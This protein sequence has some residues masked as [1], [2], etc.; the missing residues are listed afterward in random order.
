MLQPINADHKQAALSVP[1]PT[2]APNTDGADQPPRIA[3]R[4]VNPDHARH[5]SHPRH[6]PQ[7]NLPIVPNHPYHWRHYHQIVQRRVYQH[8]ILLILVITRNGQ[9]IE[10]PIAIGWRQIKSM[11]RPSV[12]HIW[13]LALRVYQVMVSLNHIMVIQRIIQSM[14][15]SI[16]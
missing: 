4:D 6:H 16:R 8:V 2:A 1:R 11:Y 13:H 5:P 7:P 12:I 3:A 15:N 9:S 14:H 10:E